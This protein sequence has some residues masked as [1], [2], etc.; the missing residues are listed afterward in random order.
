MRFGDFAVWG[1]LAAALGAVVLALSLQAGRASLRR[2]VRIVASAAAIA[3]LAT[4]GGLVL[5]R[6]VVI[7]MPGADPATPE[8]WYAAFGILADMLT[9]GAWIL[10]LL[11][12][13]QA[14]QRVRFSLFLVGFAITQTW[15]I[16]VTLPSLPFL[17]VLITWEVANPDL[18]VVPTVLITHIGTALALLGAWTLPVRDEA[19]REKGGSLSVPSANTG[20]SAAT[21]SPPQSGESNE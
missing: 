16:I 6:R 20:G 3:V 19:K 14:R 18:A 7:T 8:A 11:E 13:V 12:A 15:P 9:I 1:P 10:L 21:A 4:M 5:V 17:D 2:T